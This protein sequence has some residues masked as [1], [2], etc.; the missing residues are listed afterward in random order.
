MYLCH[1]GYRTLAQDG[2]EHPSTFNNYQW[3]TQRFSC[4]NKPIDHL[5]FKR[6]LFYSLSRSLLKSNIFCILVYWIFLRT[7]P[8]VVAPEN[9][10]L[11]FMN[12]WFI[13]VTWNLCPCPFFL[14]FRWR[15]SLS[16]V[17]MNSCWLCHWI[18][19]LPTQEGHGH[20]KQTLEHSFF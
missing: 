19:H 4:H 7:V 18:N 9:H 11:V 17:V 15:A 20:L 10:V 2:G 12:P 14:L 16:W 1:I 8:R 13:N 3:I 6:I 5:R